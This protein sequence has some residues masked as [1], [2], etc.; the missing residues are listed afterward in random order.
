MVTLDRWRPYLNTPKTIVFPRVEL[1]GRDHAPPIV[2]GVGDVRMEG[3][4]NFTFSLTGTPTDIGYAFAELRRLRENPYDGLARLRLEG[5]DSD[6]IEWAGGY[7]NPAVDMAGGS[8]KFTGEINSLSTEDRS[9]TVSQQASTELMFPL[10][11]GDP[12]TLAVSGLPTVNLPETNPRREHVVEALGSNIRFSYE[13][14]TSTFLLT[15]PSS[16]ELSAPF[17][18]NWLSEPLRI[19]F[20]QLI[21]PRLVARN[22]GG[23]RAGI[24]IRRTAGLIRGARWAALWERARPIKDNTAVWARYVQLLTL[25]A[26]AR[27]EDGRPNFEPHKIT[28]LYE[29]IIQAALGSRWVWALTFASGI[30]ALAKMLKPKDTKPT[31]SEAEAI[32]ALVSHINSWSGEPGLKRVAVSAVHRTSEITTIRML[33]ALKADGVITDI[34]LSAWEKIRNAVMHGSLVSP[35]SS[36]EE[37]GQLLSLATMTHALTGELLRRSETASEAS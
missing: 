11:V 2:V 3:T 4:S 15:A 13:D 30:E 1:I 32:G 20:G 28:R 36:A 24:Q 7:T 34:Q 12:I 10:R 22:F 8:W 37:D 18:E 9:H 29:E 31:I 35:Y 19:I 5:V 33:R 14:N 16:L 23:G 25:I 27:K 17:A 26:R 6:G 21:Y